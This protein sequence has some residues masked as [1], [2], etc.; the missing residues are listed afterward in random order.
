LPR[1][2]FADFTLSPR[3][4]VLTRA[5]RELPLIPRY[6]DL[7]VFLVEHRGEAVQRR[8]IFDR[9][10]ADVVVSDSA[11]SQAIRTLRRTLEDD[12]RDPIY[13]RT[14]S[15]HGYRFVFRELIE[16]DDDDGG[17]DRGARSPNAVESAH[18]VAAKAADLRVAGETDDRFEPLLQR[19]VAHASNPAEQEEQRDAA[20]R[21]HALGTAAALE[22][23]GVRD[24][25][26][27]ARALLRDTRWDVAG[28]GP[29]P[30]FGQ[31]GIAA[32]A[33]SLILLR[34]RRMA[35]LA[36]ARGAWA[37]IGG[38]LA[39]LCGGTVGGILL[40]V[41][42]GSEAPLA[43]AAVLG[44]VGGCCGAL[45]GAGVGAGLAVAETIG[46]SRRVLWLVA[47]GTIGG[48]AV[49]TTAQWL[50]R[51]ILST[52]VGVHVPVGGGLEGVVIGGAA[53]LAYGVATWHTAG[54]LA[55]PR[56]RDRWNT[57]LLTGLACAIAALTLT[58]G[59][60]TLVGGTV[61]AVARASAGSQAVLTPIA[62]LIGEPDFGPL[63]RALIGTCEGI[64]FGCGLALGLTHRP[65]SGRRS[66]TSH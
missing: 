35:R 48:G 7:L 17:S 24:G 40:A 54:G 26:A 9:V 37:S 66:Q 43:V 10:W 25:H 44:V 13:I 46:R 12:S 49:G 30:L 15:R 2:R 27:R 61:H 39:G 1:Y 51:S 8:E 45:G 19:L 31:P 14:V 65:S 22:R 6:F 18:D 29:V 5:G 20:E 50:G 23:L 57:T 16:E 53:G 59:G 41:A 28:A 32:T 36:A 21:L 56:G 38:G 64:V 4:R 33:A 62:R 52:I 47:G 58:I 34:L 11:L 42:P 3:T 55:A 60:R 63:T